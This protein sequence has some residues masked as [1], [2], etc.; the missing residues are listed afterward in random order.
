MLLYLYQ[1]NLTINEAKFKMMTFF[2]LKGNKSCGYDEISAK[3]VRGFMRKCTNHFIFFSK[4][5]IT[6]FFQMG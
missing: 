6:L 1:K 2:A 3:I 4:L 5:L